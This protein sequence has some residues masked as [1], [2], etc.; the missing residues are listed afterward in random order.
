MSYL[1]GRYITDE[2]LDKIQ[3]HKY[4]SGGYSWLDYKMTPWWEWFVELMPR[5][6]APN[7]LT[8][9][10]LGFTVFFYVIIAAFDL[11]LSRDV[12]ARTLIGFA[13]GNFMYQ[14][15]DAIDGKQARRT[16]NSSP[17]GQLFDH[18]CDA[19]SGVTIGLAMC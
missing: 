17:L 15:F 11:S 13:F 19:L 14:T 16:G 6:V 3:N 10:G 2:G 9:I 7:T 1:V 12:P 8:L 18:G 4:V 5:Y